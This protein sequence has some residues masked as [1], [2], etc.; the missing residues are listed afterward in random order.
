MNPF[1]AIFRLD[2]ID[3]VIVPS[4][5][6]YPAS[7]STSIHAYPLVE[8]CK[9]FA[10]LLRIAVKDIFIRIS[11]SGL[12]IMTKDCKR[13][14]ASCWVFPSKFSKIVK[15]HS[16]PHQKELQ[17]PEMHVSAQNQASR[18]ACSRGCLQ[19]M[20]G[21]SKPSIAFLRLRATDDFKKR[22]LKPPLAVAK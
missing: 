13:L 15:L 12:Q 20:N 1:G 5:S 7:H 16:A 4:L 10:S 2:L 22:E 21:H 6:T 17:P 8:L 14:Q 18:P 19:P 9:G 11:H 3:K